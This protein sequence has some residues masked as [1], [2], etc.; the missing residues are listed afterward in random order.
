MKIFRCD[1]KNYCAKCYLDILNDT[2][3][4]AL[5]FQFTFLDD[6]DNDYKCDNCKK[7][8]SRKESLNAFKHIV[9]IIEDINKEN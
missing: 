7:L 6:L 8:I 1:K 5:V 4:K 3:F 2:E 9:K